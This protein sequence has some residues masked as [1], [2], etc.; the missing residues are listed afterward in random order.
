GNA[1][2]DLGTYAGF[3]PYVGAGAGFSLV[4]WSNLSKDQFCEGRGCPLTYAGNAS[5]SGD[6]DWRF[7]WQ[8]M[9]G[10]AYDVTRN[11]KVDLGYRYRRIAGGAM[12]GYDVTNTTLGADGHHS[13]DNGYSQHS[14]NVGL[15]YSLW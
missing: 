6:S 13:R 7:T 14:V 8:L 3:T 9:A 12:H 10:M 2:A 11:L 5:Y 15:R 4:N 1:Y